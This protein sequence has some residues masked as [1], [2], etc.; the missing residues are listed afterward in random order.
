M[1]FVNFVHV[2]SQRDVTIPT[3]KTVIVIRNLT[4]S[5]LWVVFINANNSGS[6]QY[7]TVYNGDIYHIFDG[8]LSTV[9]LYD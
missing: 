5:D 4:I 1:E 3:N 7:V 8:A 2:S 6:D 9:D